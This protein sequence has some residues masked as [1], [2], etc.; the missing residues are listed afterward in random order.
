WLITAHTFLLKTEKGTREVFAEASKNASA[1]PAAYLVRQQNR[2]IVKDYLTALETK[3]M[4]LFA[5]LL[6]DDMVLEMP[7]SPKGY[8]ERVAGKMNI[9]KHFSNWPEISGA[10]DFTSELTFYRMTSPE[11]IFAEW[12]GEVDILATGRKYQQQYAGLFHIVAGKIKLFRE[13]YDPAS[14]AYA[15]GLNESE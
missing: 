8:P 1:K 12:K 14:F 10:A 3:N 2:K 4:D 15:L 9:I 7:Y 13:Y 5:D 11:M 6:A